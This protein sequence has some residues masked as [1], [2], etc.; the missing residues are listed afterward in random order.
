[1]MS[2]SATEGS[3][4][5]SSA[6]GAQRVA[7]ADAGGGEQGAKLRLGLLMF[8]GGIVSTYAPTLIKWVAV[9]K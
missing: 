2:L 1:M 4:R 7:G 9:G 6:A 5:P 3:M 8:V